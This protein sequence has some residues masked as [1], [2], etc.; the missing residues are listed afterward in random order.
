MDIS[1]DNRGL[2]MDK[3]LNNQAMIITLDVDSHL[4]E[5]VLQ[6]AQAGLKMV[7][8][9]SV[10]PQLLATLLNDFPNLHIGAGNILNTDQLESCHRAGAHFITSPGLLPEIVQTAAIYDI[11]YL[12]GIATMSEAMHAFNLGC[13]HVRPYPAN[14]AFCSRLNKCIP[15]LRLYPAEVEWEEAEHFLNLPSVAAISTLNPNKSHLQALEAS[16]S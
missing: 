5:R 12:P 8:I 4:Y 6:I 3:F 2:A 9:N 7:E 10:D 13:H 16:V 14:L 15:L 11:H 1:N